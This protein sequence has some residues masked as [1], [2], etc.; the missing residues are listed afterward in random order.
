[1]PNPIEGGSE[2]NLQEKLDAYKKDFQK[3]V[4]AAALELMHRTTDELRNSGILKET[5]KPG[6]RAPDFNLKNADNRDVALGD[7][8]KEGKVILSFYRG[9]W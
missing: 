4:P 1:M 7:L 8:L 5:V 3:K 6:D 9:S 2:M